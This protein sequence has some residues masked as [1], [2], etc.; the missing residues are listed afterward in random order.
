MIREDK[1]IKENNILRA[2]PGFVIAVLAVLILLIAAVTIQSALGLKTAVDRT[3]K[4]YVSDVAAQLA[5][6]IDDRLSLYQENNI[7]GV[8]GRN[9]K[10]GKHAAFDSAGEL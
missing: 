8:W 6:D 10:Q 7:I 2:E 4:A 5:L 3:T 1:R 9:R